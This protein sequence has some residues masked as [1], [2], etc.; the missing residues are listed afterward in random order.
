MDVVDVL[1]ALGALAQHDGRTSRVVNMTRSQER[2]RK[3]IDR[4]S[5]LLGPLTEL[6]KLLNGRVAWSFT[7]GAGRIDGNVV[8]AVT[9]EELQPL[10]R[11][12][13]ALTAKLHDSLLGL[14]ILGGRG[15]L[16]GA[17]RGA[18]R[19]GGEKVSSIHT[20][21]ES[22]HTS[23]MRYKPTSKKRGATATKRATVSA[24]FTWHL[25]QA[26]VNQRGIRALSGM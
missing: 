22:Y 21:S 2:R 19:G 23:E 4:Y 3:H 18:E 1:V 11:R 26:G 16:R 15:R 25:S 5:V 14:V 17:Q 24:F 10:V 20:W 12:R 7:L 6:R 13:R 8:D 9:L